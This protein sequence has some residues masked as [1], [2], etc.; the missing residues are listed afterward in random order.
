MLL[1]LLR[2]SA[3]ASLSS[4]VMHWISICSGKFENKNQRASLFKGERAKDILPGKI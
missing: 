4:K 1:V 2:I 3:F